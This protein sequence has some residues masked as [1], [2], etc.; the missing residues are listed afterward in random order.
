MFHEA[1][2]TLGQFLRPLTL[3]LRSRASSTW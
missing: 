2:R 1:Q 3:A